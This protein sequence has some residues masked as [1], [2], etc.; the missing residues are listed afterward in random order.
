MSGLRFISL[1]L[2]NFKN[3]PEAEI[4]LDRAPGLYFISGRNKLNPEL[5]ANGVGKSSLWDAMLWALWG[6]TGRDARPAA[7]VTPWGKKGMTRVHLR[8]MRGNEQIEI[9]RTRNPNYLELYEEDGPRE[10]VQE[11]VP[12]ILGMTEEMFRRT[13]ILGQF[14]TLFLDLRPE[15]QSQMFTEA[16]SLDV[17]LK[18]VK[19]ANDDMADLYRQRD[20]FESKLQTNVALADAA[21]RQLT[22]AKDQAESFETDRANRLEKITVDSKPLRGDLAKLRNNPVEKPVPATNK[23]LDQLRRE[24][25]PIQQERAVMMRDLERSQSDLNRLLKK[26]DD[27]KK[28]KSNPTCSQCGQ[29]MP[30]QKQK[31]YV[32]GLVAE[33]EE[34]NKNVVVMEIKAKTLLEKSN[35]LIDQIAEEEATQRTAAKQYDRKLEAWTQWDRQIFALNNRLDEAERNYKRIKAETNMALDAITQAKDTGKRL[36]KE[37][38]DIKDRLKQTDIGYEQAK[39]WTEAFR[40][41]RLS[42]IDETLVELE[43]AASRHASMLGL[44]DWGIKFDTERETA[45]GKVSAGFTVLLYPPDQDEPVKW[46]SY[47]GGESQRWQL[48]TSMALSEVL[49]SRAGL[50]PNMECYDEPTRGLS[51]SGVDDLLERLR[52]RALELGRVV[53][54]VDHHSLDKGSFDGVLMVTKTKQGSDLTWQ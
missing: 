8:F 21:D 30:Q 35:V 49:L 22:Q 4:K 28:A 18:A 7:A 13:I 45:S 2:E 24:L 47:S 39:F 43:M 31:E 36:A 52:D 34:L 26:L 23:K 12:R 54:F 25:A 32:R 16:L 33:S 48:A 44:E 20:A 42:I 14:G 1:T 11:D 53:W 50:S 38:N 29:P 37:A 19:V 3:F 10:I 41:I 5:G 40:E 46:E 9:V 17:W 51:S 15:Q 27:E 6:R